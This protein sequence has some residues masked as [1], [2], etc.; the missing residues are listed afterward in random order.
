MFSLQRSI[1]RFCRYVT[2]LW[3]SFA[4]SAHTTTF[5]CHALQELKGLPPSWSTAG[6][7]LRKQPALFVPTYR[8]A[9]AARTASFS[10]YRRVPDAATE[11]GMEGMKGG[12]KP[13]KGYAQTLFRDRTSACNTAEHRFANSLRQRGKFDAQTAAGD[14]A[15]QTGGRRSSSDAGKDSHVHTS[16]HKYTAKM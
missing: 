2:W 6:N 13:G 9:P 10:S 15:W 12:V 7:T 3:L 11:G 14:S 5:V 8:P 1:Y 16:T 4:F